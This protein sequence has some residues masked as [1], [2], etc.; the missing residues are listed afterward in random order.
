VKSLTLGKP[1]A[2]EVDL[3][4]FEGSIVRECSEFASELGKNAIASRSQSVN[5]LQISV[6]RPRLDCVTPSEL[7]PLSTKSWCSEQKL[8]CST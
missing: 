4:F 2:S 3:T 6:R 8:I 7:P 1:C 5:G